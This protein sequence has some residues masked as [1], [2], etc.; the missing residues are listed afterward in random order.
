MTQFDKAEKLI[1][2]MQ[3]MV[4]TLERSRDVH[5]H[6]QIDQFYYMQKSEELITL[7]TL[8]NEANARVDRLMGLIKRNYSE[9]F[10]EW[11]R[12]MRRMNDLMRCRRT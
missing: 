8:L 5:V 10:C 3:L 12:D 4:R 6:Q 2:K 7:L 1:R 9:A 11:Q